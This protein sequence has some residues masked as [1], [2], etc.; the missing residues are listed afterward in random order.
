[1]DVESLKILNPWWQNPNLIKED[2][3]LL[4]RAQPYYFDHPCKI[5]IPLEPG[6]GVILRGPRQVGKTTLMKEKIAE[7]LASGN[8]APSNCIFVSCEAFSDF[9]KLQEFLTQILQSRAGQDTV[10]CLDEVTF[11]PEWQR[12]V[13]WLANAGLLKRAALLISGSDAHDLKLSAERFPGRNIKELRIYP[14]SSF[15]YARIAFFKN[16]SPMERFETYLKVGGFPR[17]IADYCL[18]GFV[19]DET[20]EMYLNWILGDSHRYDLSREL[21][22]HIL[23]RIYETA[24]SQVT[25]T[26]L[27]EKTPVKSFETALSYVEHLDLAFLCHVVACYDP[28]K[29]LPAPRKARKVYFVDPL[30]Y[31]IAGG[32]VQGVRRV[33]DWWNKTL[34]ENGIRGRIFESV[35]LDSFCRKTQ[36]V[37]FWYS[38][39]TK[40]EVDVLIRRADKIKVFEVKWQPT[41]IKPILGEDVY[42]ITPQEFVKGEMF[43]ES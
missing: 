7:A 4:V 20:Y 5:K 2:E 10:L 28:D 9:E 38:A 18:Y 37:Y 1:M 36:P 34:T 40:R 32:Y 42:V 30:L 27:I 43:I 31:A 16:L 17:A 6:L 22:G 41:Q 33:H 8:Y 24:G 11:V 12:A 35:V 3:H 21:M 25:W 15:D 26:R 13:L 23:Y 19:R 14:L 39:N 29:E